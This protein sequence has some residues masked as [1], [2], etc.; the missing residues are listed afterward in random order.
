MDWGIILRSREVPGPQ[1]CPIPLV[2]DKR[3]GSAAA[4]LPARLQ[5]EF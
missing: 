5:N 2:F 4:E 3:L 1:H